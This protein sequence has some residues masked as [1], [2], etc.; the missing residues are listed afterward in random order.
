MQTLIQLQEVERLRE[1]G[2]LTEAYMLCKHAYDKEPDN[3]DVLAA[4][5]S[6]ALELSYFDTVESLSRHALA[7]DPGKPDIWMMLAQALAAQNNDEEAKKAEALAQLSDEAYAELRI[8][9]AKKHM[10]ERHMGPA[11]ALLERILSD[12]PDHEQA[13]QL[14]ANINNDSLH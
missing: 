9:A 14:L 7:Q 13:K 4:M 12:I 3:V 2:Q 8:N 1:A 5:A 11:K 10:E 6:L